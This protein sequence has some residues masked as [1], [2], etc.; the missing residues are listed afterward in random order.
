[1]MWGGFS[2]YSRN[3]LTLTVG[4]LL[5]IS[6]ATARAGDGPLNVSLGD[7]N[8]SVGFCLTDCENTG[9]T[10]GGNGGITPGH[11]SWLVDDVSQ[12]TQ[13]WFWY[14]TSSTSPEFPVSNL[15]Y[16][17]HMLADTNPFSDDRNDTLSVMYTGGGFEMELSFQLRG[18]NA[19][20]MTSDLAEQIRIKNTGTVPLNFS[21]FQYVDFDLDGTAAGDTAEVINPNTVRQ[22]GELSSVSE[23]VVSPD[24]T[25]HEVALFNST[26]TKLLN[27]MPDNLNNAN[28]PVMGDVTWAFQWDFI[29]QPNQSFTIQK[30][31]NI[32]KVPEPASLALAAIGLAALRR[33]MA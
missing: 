17:G 33:R 5:A 7:R 29:L 8:S 22:N 10:E 32:A 23:T 9:S 24:P 18:G 28:G 25:A 4:T 6:T 2:N 21:I 31:K 19:G 13:E 26:L 16:A 20:S 30:D 15:N 27:G 14:R 12:L 3:I 11:N 1:M